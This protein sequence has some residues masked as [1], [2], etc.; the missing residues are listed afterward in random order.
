[1]ARPST[2]EQRRREVVD[3]ALEAAAEH[4]LRNLSLTDVANQAGVT[5]GAL[6]YYYEDLDAILVEAHAAGMR[7][8]GEDRE[9]LVAQAERPAEQLAI[10]IRA[11]LPSGPDDALMRLLY[12]FDVLA[13]KSPLH[14]ELVQRLY[15]EQLALYR[16]ILEAGVATGDFSLTGPV[17]DIAM[18]FVALED[19]YGLHIVAGGSISVADAERAIALFARQAGAPLPTPTIGV[20]A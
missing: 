18:N 11:G 3:A 2:Q 6:L 16:R 17:D 7:R 20:P 9:A 8:V 1:M 13:G 12:E 4:G 15:G 10:A 19:A 14:D 5:R